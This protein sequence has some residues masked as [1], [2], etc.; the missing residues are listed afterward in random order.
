MDKGKVP[1]EV[2]SII[3]DSSVK[4][5]GFQA[6]KSCKELTYIKIPS[7]VIFIRI[8]AFYMCTSL[9]SIV[10]PN[11]MKAVGIKAF[12]DCSALTSINIPPSM[13]RIGEYA[14]HGCRALR[15]IDIPSSVIKIGPYTFLNCISLLSIMIPPSLTEI[16]MHAFHGCRSLK[17][18]AIPH[19]VTI[20]G[21]H[22]FYCCD[23][24]R[25]ILNGRATGNANLNEEANMIIL[26]RNRF[27]KL[28]LHQ[29]CYNLD[30][31]STRYLQQKLIKDIIKTT[32][33]LHCKDMFGMTALDILCSNPY[34]T[35]EVFRTF[36]TSTSL[37]P[38][39]T[40]YSN[41]RMLPSPCVM[42]NNRMNGTFP[43][44][45]FFI[46]RGLR[47]NGTCD[48]DNNSRR[49]PLDEALKQGINHLDLECLFAL[50]VETMSEQRKV[51]KETGLYYFLNAALYPQCG[52]DVCYFLLRNNADL[53]LSSCGRKKKKYKKRTR[54]ITG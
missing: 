7:S 25:S 39:R 30:V 14:F 18:I 20:I 19:S 41:S 31:A 34:V 48:I 32:K 40:T 21:A 15:S 17:V 10:L 33:Y 26:L 38:K 8:E 22:A 12:Y 50:D 24:L 46:C 16:G 11:S 9:S 5:V 52:L 53:L 3:V 4:I 37:H 51:D 6:F 27:A 45:M 29:A 2:V 49:L 1:K 43:L 54:V 42:K 47:Y 23:T 13:K 28:P 36:I 35:P 44:A